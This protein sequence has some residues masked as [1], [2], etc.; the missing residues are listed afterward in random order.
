MLK[1]IT[2]KGH[3]GEDQNHSTIYHGS[4]VAEVFAAQAYGIL[5]AFVRC[6]SGDCCIGTT[7]E[8]RNGF[9]TILV[10][11]K[12]TTSTNPT[13]KSSIAVSNS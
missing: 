2:K 11:L 6:I 1:S 12:Y 10:N 13:S 7:T 5:V 3:Q 4:V 9:T 8:F